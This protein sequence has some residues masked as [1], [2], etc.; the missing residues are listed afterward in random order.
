LVRSAPRLDRWAYWEK[1]DHGG[2]LGLP[3]LAVT[4]LMLMYPGNKP[5]PAGWT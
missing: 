5:H 2:I 1:F 4:G 3:L